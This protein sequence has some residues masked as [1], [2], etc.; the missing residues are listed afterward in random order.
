MMIIYQNP[1]KALPCKIIKRKKLSMFIGV[2]TNLETNINH[3]ML[4]LK[5]S[6]SFHIPPT[7]L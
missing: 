2:A 1:E 6:S 4:V 7:L 3:F 5:M